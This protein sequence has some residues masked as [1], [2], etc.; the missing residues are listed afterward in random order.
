MARSALL[1]PIRTTRRVI[2][3]AT[4]TTTRKLVAG[5]GALSILGGGGAGGVNLADHT[6]LLPHQVNIGGYTLT[7][8]NAHPEP[9]DQ[10]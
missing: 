10:P 2:R 6:G 5:A 8:G 1:H 3:S 9:D 4:R 7:I